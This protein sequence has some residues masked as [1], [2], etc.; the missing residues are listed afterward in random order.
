MNRDVGKPFL[1]DPFE[2]RHQISNVAVNQRLNAR[3][4]HFRSCP[5]MSQR[6]LELV[7]R[8]FLAA[9]AERP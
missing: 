1:G 2:R 3:D 4:G 6:V 7:E 5:R 9:F 8:A